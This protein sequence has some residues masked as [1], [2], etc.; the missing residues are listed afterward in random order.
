MRV[1]ISNCTIF[2]KEQ[3]LVCARIR[4]RA[5]RCTCTFHV[6]HSRSLP[7]TQ[8]S[9]RTSAGACE[10]SKLWTLCKHTSLRVPLQIRLDKHYPIHAAMNWLLSA[11]F[12]WPNFGLCIVRDITIGTV[13]HCKSGFG[14]QL[15][16]VVNGWCTSCCDRVLRRAWNR[17]F[18]DAKRGEQNQQRVHRCVQQL[19][20]WSGKVSDPAKGKSTS[21]FVCCDNLGG[22]KDLGQHTEL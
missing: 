2:H 13:Y 18:A 6:T 4:E 3:N 7:S 10:H 14:R 11:C 16:T 19:L 9:N 15:D 8:E 20:G 1:V 22:Y 17:R 12:Y 5:F 21:R